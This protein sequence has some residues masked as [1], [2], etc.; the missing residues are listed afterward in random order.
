MDSE[1]RSLWH[2]A[3]ELDDTLRAGD[4]D[5]ALLAAKR[6]HP[7]PYTREK[8]FS[9]MSH[10]R[11]VVFN[12]YVVPLRGG[13]RGDIAAT[14]VD[15][16]RHGFPRSQKA[17]VQRGPGRYRKQVSVHELLDVWQRG[18]GVISVTDLHVRGTRVT[19]TMNIDGLAEFNLLRT[20]SSDMAYQEMM[21]LVISSSRNVTDSHSD[22][23]DGSNHAFLGRKLWLAWETFEGEAA[24]LEDNSRS[25]IDD[26][27]AF[28]LRAWLSLPSACWWTV[29]AGETLF[30]PGRLTHK[31]V[32]LEKYL[33][34]GGFYVALPCA[35]NT[36]TRWTQH[37]ALWELHTH[38][39]DH[40]VPQITRAI[41]KKV[42]ELRDAP[43]AMQERWGY[44]F[45]QHDLD[46]LEAL[47]EATKRRLLQNRDFAGMIDE[48]RAAAGSSVINDAACYST[49]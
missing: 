42:R 17:R 34:V 28:D 23:P 16:Y 36:I 22:D 7:E 30:L 38:K 6:I 3:A 47:D 41:A 18:R 29:S 32:T 25:Q 1:L 2:Q 24:G 44:D 21:T 46:E 11:P 33:G 40:L 35:I 15:L 4:D 43:R 37:K 48:V 19:K 12:D 14:L 8:L 9:R 31:V 13:D 20:G 10:G 39:N 45:L 49:A 27:A 26:K 5:L